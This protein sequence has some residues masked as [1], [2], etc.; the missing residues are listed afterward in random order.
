LKKLAIITTHPI[1]YN[2]PWFRLL[3]ERKKV[4]PKVFYTWGQ[5]EAEAKFDPGFG[6]KV[7]WDIP[8]LEGYEHTFVKNVAVDPGSHHHKGINNPSLI[9]ELEAWNPDAILVFGWNFKSHLK[10]LRHFKK[11]KTLLFRGDSHLLDETEGV[12][13]KKQLRRVFLKWV[14]SH[15][16]KALY[17]GKANNEYFRVHGLKKQQL[18]FA[19]HAIDNNRFLQKNAISLRTQWNIPADDLIFLY[20]G[21]LEPKKNLPF[22]MDSFVGA[23]MQN[24]HLVLV[25]SGSMEAELKNRWKALDPEVQQHI[26]FMN[27]QNQAMM[28]VVYQSCDIFVLPSRG[29][30]ETWGLA[31]NEAMAAGKPVLVSDACGC[32]ANLVSNGSNGLVFKN[33][34]REDLI[35]KMKQLSVQEDTLSAMGRA[36]REIITPWS[37]EEICI[38][39]EQTLE[40]NP[41]KK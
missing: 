18:V 13:I 24:T 33:N 8:L 19:P 39:L 41:G 31:V 20:A 27:F 6:K 11:K 22:L 25:G 12:S 23:R 3:A 32:S 26:H 16:D 21:K 37:F 36:S 28:P 14:Y 38:A 40:E 4:Q 9:N 2:A 34:D 35:N 30:G 17:V 15:I 10:V 7:V 29:P 1:Q 5:L